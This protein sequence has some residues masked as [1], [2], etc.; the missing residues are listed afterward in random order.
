MFRPPPRAPRKKRAT[1]MAMAR[2]VGRATG[3]A[4]KTSLEPGP[5]SVAAAQSG[6]SSQ[7]DRDDKES[8]A[9]WAEF[10]EHAAAHAAKS[11]KAAKIIRDT[12]VTRKAAGRSVPTKVTYQRSTTVSSN[13]P[14]K[15]PKAR[16]K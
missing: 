3:R 13:V 11:E 5:S 12:V 1:P 10:A 16:D 9:F 6:S 15:K 7:K 4:H 14:L 2:G 8:E